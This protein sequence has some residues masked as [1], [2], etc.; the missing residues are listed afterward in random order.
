MRK[1]VMTGISLLLVFSVASNIFLLGRVGQ[2]SKELKRNNNRISFIENN[3]EKAVNEII[4]VETSSKDENLL[5]EVKFNLSELT[6]KKAKKAMMNV[7]FKLKRMDPATKTYV[8]I[9]SGEEEQFLKEIIPIND[10][11][12]R[13]EREIS[14]L[15]PLRV[16]LVIEKYGEKKLINLVLED[17]MYKRFV[18][19]TQ[20]ELL[21]FDYKYQAE[22][23]NLLTSFSTKI[24][25]TPL[26]DSEIQE[27]YVAVEK[28]GIPVK[29]LP[30]EGHVEGQD[31]DSVFYSMEI[32]DLKLLG[33]DGDQIVMAIILKEKNSFVHRYEFVKCQF[34]K[35]IENIKADNSPILTLK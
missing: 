13:I 10:T 18:G 20:F 3:F 25:Y 26:E 30:L 31:R 19:E 5:E 7:E 35:G 8:S 15:R 34:E 1:Y 24:R 28:N 29:V 4:L 6:D 21:D 2:M 12:Y 14:I 9:E 17:E 27:S 16:D 32:S 11:T 33:M 23:G 22:S